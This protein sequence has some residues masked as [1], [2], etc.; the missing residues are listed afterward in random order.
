MR[1][2]LTLELL[3]RIAHHTFPAPNR[4]ATEPLHKAT[5]D[6]MC[7]ATA[8]SLD[9]VKSLILRMHVCLGTEWQTTDNAHGAPA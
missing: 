7:A 9:I 8:H 6:L 3:D 4:D 2:V 1:G 5:M